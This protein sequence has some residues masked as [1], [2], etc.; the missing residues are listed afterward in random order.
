M[1]FIKKLSAL[2]VKRL[3]DQRAMGLSDSDTCHAKNDTRH[4]EWE[5]WHI[6]M[7]CLFLWLTTWDEHD[8]VMLHYQTYNGSF[9]VL[10]EM[11]NL[12]SLSH[13]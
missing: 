2:R 10:C 7:K 5:V 4:G 11:K 8:N 3:G 9:L 12:I 1:I 13:I 6:T